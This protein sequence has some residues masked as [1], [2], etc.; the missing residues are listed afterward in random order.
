MT[1][2]NVQFQ[3]EIRSCLEILLLAFLLTFSKQLLL[4]QSCGSKDAR[5]LTFNAR[6]LLFAMREKE[7]LC[8]LDLP[9]HDS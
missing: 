1:I 9:W 6:K 3:E 2:S 7:A 8:V 5:Q 4:V